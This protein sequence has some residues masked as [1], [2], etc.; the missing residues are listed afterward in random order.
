MHL[1]PLVMLM[2]KLEVSVI[3]LPDLETW[4]GLR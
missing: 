2:L 4:T 1:F 3:R